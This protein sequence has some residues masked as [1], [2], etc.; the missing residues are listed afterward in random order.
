MIKSEDKGVFMYAFHDGIMAGE[1]FDTPEDAVRNSH[2][3]WGPGTDATVKIIR[4]VVRVDGVLTAR[5]R[6]TEPTL[7][8]EV[9]P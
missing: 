2:M 8:I 1:M 7:E 4:Y 3:D 9:E 6:V 5:V